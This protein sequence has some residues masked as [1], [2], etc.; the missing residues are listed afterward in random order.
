MH[1]LN[2]V[3]YNRLIGLI[4]FILNCNLWMGEVFEYSLSIDQWER[5]LEYSSARGHCIFIVPV[6]LCCVPMT[7]LIKYSLNMF[8]MER[9]FIF[10]YQ[11]IF[12]SSNKYMPKPVLAW[13]CLDTDYS[14]S[15]CGHLGFL[16]YGQ[17]PPYSLHGLEPS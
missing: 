10:I 13:V 17:K 11:W 15:R 4:L 12:K 14:N 1:E 7:K 9:H 16:L 2:V 8:L 6:V 5:S 3:M